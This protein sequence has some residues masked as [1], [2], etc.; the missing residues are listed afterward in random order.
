LAAI[1]GKGG[2]ELYSRNLLSFNAAYKS[3]VEEL[4]KI[5]HVAL[6]DGELVVEDEAGRSHFQLLQNYRKDNKGPLKY[7]VFDLLNLDGNDLRE[8]PLLQRKELLKIL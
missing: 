3:I 8:L 1:D 5:D 6:L 2:V 7:Y 4:E